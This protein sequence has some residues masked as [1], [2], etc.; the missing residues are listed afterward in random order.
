M[1]LCL[2]RFNRCS[3]RRVNIGC[4]AP[5]LLIA[6]SLPLLN[7][8]PPA[9]SPME[10]LQ[11]GLHLADLYNWGDAANDFGEAEGMFAA[12][13][14]VR[15]ALYARLGKIRSTIEQRSLPAT[16]EDLQGELDS[17]PLLQN[18]KQLRM[19]CLIV[20]GDI[21]GEFNS[22]AMRRDWENVQALARELRG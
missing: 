9:P 11:R 4:R 16:S 21:D 14:D 12:A 10:I 20:K 22:G 19:F 2:A 3:L 13:G 17:N 6:L 7:A 5:I 18:D 15:N 1:Q 8:Q